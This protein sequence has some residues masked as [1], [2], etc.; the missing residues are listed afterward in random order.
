MQRSSHKRHPRRR[1]LPIEPLE[2]RAMFNIAVDVAVNT[3]ATLQ[4]IRGFGAGSHYVPNLRDDSANRA[5]A[6]LLDVDFGA[7]FGR[8]KFLLLLFELLELI[9]RLGLAFVAL[10]G[11]NGGIARRIEQL[12]VALVDAFVFILHGLEVF[13]HAGLVIFKH[14]LRFALSARPQLVEPSISTQTLGCF[15]DQKLRHRPAA[16]G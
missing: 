12:L 8:E 1:S 4:T 10:V 3:N 2:R 14:S 16:D 15:V 7:T 5:L 9:V 11:G 6:P 13:L